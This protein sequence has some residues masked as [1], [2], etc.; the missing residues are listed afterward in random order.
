MSNPI[1]TKEQKERCLDLWGCIPVDTNW[2]LSSRLFNEDKWDLSGWETKGYTITE[3]PFVLRSDLT[4]TYSGKIVEYDNGDTSLLYL[5]GMDCPLAEELESE[6]SGKTVS[7]SW[8][9]SDTKKEENEFI[10]NGILTIC[11]CCH[12]DYGAVYSGVTGYLWTNEEVKIGDHDLIEIIH[13]N[14][15]KYILLKIKIHS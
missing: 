12:A 9:I 6:I 11:G 14:I 7:A 10:E 4:L 2:V 1:L 15:G 8:F 5:E 3:S 13:R